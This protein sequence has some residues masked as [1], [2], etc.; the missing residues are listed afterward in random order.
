MLHLPRASRASSVSR[1]ESLGLKDLPFP[2]TA[3]AN[4]YSPDPRLDG[5]IYAEAPVVAEI[6]RFERL[7]ICPDDFPNRVQLAYLWAQGDQQSSRGMGKTALLRYFLQRINRDWGFTEFGGQFSAVVIYVS[8]PSQ[9]TTRYMEQLA[10]SA[11]VDICKNGVLAASRAVLRLNALSDEQ[12]KSVM[13]GPDG[14]ENPGNLLDDDVL[15]NNGIQPDALDANIADYLRKAGVESAASTALAN[16]KFEQHLRSLRRGENLEPFYVPNDVKGLYFS[17]QLLFND[18]VHYLR[19]AGFAGGYLFIDDIE[20][21][22]EQMS[23]RHRISFAKDFRSCTVGVGY[24]NTTY[25]FFSSVLTTHQNIAGGL[26]QAWV[27][28]GLASAAHLSPDSPNSVNLPLPSRDQAREIIVAHL[29]H[30]RLDQSEKGTT[31]PFTEEGLDA[32]LEN[33]RTMPRELLSTAAN[34]VSKAAEEGVTTI[35]AATVR[36]AIEGSPSMAMP[37]PTE[38]LA[39]AL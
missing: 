38:G 33:R 4:P 35:D 19:V 6:K 28:A 27:E 24:A 25:K 23:R 31:K 15:R 18:M 8:F 29:D 1:Y 39:D 32:L 22:V 17:K 26:S 30:Y 21:L 12:A 37:D 20:N 13:T 36:S 10:W 7:L 34:V 9:V 14:S 16:G 5:T 11:L 3:I 2:N